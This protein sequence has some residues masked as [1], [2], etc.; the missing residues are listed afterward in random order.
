M[1]QYEQ[2]TS[3]PTT[4]NNATPQQQESQVDQNQRQQKASNTGRTSDELRTSYERVAFLGDALRLL[5]Q[6]YLDSTFLDS[7]KQATE[8]ADEDILVQA[9][10]TAM[11]SDL[12]FGD[13]MRRGQ[14]RHDER[15]SKR[16]NSN[17]DHRQMLISQALYFY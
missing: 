17:R 1:S 6:C 4:V 12:G 10:L 15:Q 7:E 14:K 16:D 13:V 8:S 2:K 11:E 9:N 5:S 3:P